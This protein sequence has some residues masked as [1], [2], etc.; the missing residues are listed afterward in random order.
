MEELNM[1]V[2]IVDFT[3]EW[4]WEATLTQKSVGWFNG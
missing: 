3:R 4:N 2:T 1:Y